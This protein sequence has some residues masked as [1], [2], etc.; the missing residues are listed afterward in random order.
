[1]F[2]RSKKWPGETHMAL[3]CITEPHDLVSSGV[4]FKDE[5]PAWT[6]LTIS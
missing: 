4:V 1:L 2:F 3:A 6:A 5:L